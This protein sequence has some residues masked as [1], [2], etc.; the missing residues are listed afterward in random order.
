MKL[1]DFG[2]SH[3]LLQVTSK[4]CCPNKFVGHVTTKVSDSSVIVVMD[5]PDKEETTTGNAGTGP[6]ARGIRSALRSYGILTP[7]WT[8]VVHCGEG[9]APSNA[10]L[11]ACRNRAPKD[12][13]GYP[14]VLL[15]GAGAVNLFFPKIRNNK[16]WGN[17]AYH[18]DFPGQRFYCMYHPLR[19]RAKGGD[20]QDVYEVQLR[21]FGRIVS[22]EPD[23]LFDLHRAHDEGFT[24]AVYQALESKK[25]CF[26]IETPRIRPWRS[27]A[28]IRSIAFTHDGYNVFFCEEHDMHWEWFTQ[29]ICDFLEDSSKQVINHHVGFD[30]GWMETMYGIIVRARQLDTMTLFHHVRGY[31][32]P[33][34]KMLVSVELD[35][36]RHLCVN[37]DVEEDTEI[38]GYYNAED[39]I[40]PW[41]L[42][43]IGIKELNP[44]QLDLWLQVASPSELYLERLNING[45]YVDMDHWK[46]KREQLIDEREQAIVAWEME[47]KAFNRS[48]L[49]GDKAL[50]TYLFKK[51]G[52][53]ILQ[54]TPTGIAKLDKEVI[55]LLIDEEDATYLCNLQEIRRIDKLQST[56]VDGLKDHIDVD[57]RV[58][59]SY[60]NTWTDTGRASGRNP[61]MQNQPR[62]P[63]IRKM[64]A[65]RPGYVFLD[66]D[67]SQIELR[68]MF[69][70]AEDSA[71]I[72]AYLAGSDVHALT[73]EVLAG[74]NFTG[75]DRTSAKA[76][77]FAL[78][79][80]G[81]E[82][83]IVQSARRDYGLNWSMKE[84]KEF[85]DSFFGT[86]TT[87]S[88][89]HK[90]I[91]AELRS[92]R[93]WVQSPTGYVHRY[94]HWNSGD[95][96]TRDH[97]ERSAINAYGQSP[98]SY[99]TMHTGIVAQNLLRERGLW[100]HVQ[101]VNTVHDSLSWEVREDLVDETIQA[102]TEGNQA[103]MDW[104]RHW[105]LVPLVVDFEM[106][107]SW[108]E[109]EEL[110]V[111]AVAYV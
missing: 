82:Y 72:E 48:V 55:A 11:A 105:F 4:V 28:K 19:G 45:I 77:N 109:K 15:V 26:D 18:P 96:K 74:P 71:A 67:Y 12:V 7:A 58:H 60:F 3:K 62:D 51:K 5:H 78:L 87:L 37:P 110:E 8:Y 1:T 106:G 83:T 56:Y 63:S 14:F 39:V 61:N 84:G 24:E 70:A 69:S 38:L 23:D 104:V 54:T 111:K 103:T 32:M 17:L 35:G 88:P 81:T 31:K 21:R 9:K 34:L 90:K 86:Y 33:S 100:P 57:G 91:I 47:D 107:S 99:M 75:K 101:L 10:C 66:A 64:F 59:G 42:L 20:S 44:G 2:P 102:I 43:E 95:Q 89:L 6:N 40:Y 36:Y 30:L 22:E 25:I 68:V 65:A 97:V 41:H 94:E 93:G 13:K 16:L 108:G 80:G 73:A 98:A 50:R 76:I 46:V 52:L 29:A 27:T 85:K 53:P 92:N 49:D 79:Y